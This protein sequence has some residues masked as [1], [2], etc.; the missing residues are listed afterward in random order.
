MTTFTHMH[1]MRLV[2]PF[3]NELGH[4]ELLALLL[5]ISSRKTSEVAVRNLKVNSKFR[6]LPQE[7]DTKWSVQSALTRAG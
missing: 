1:T 7:V 6:S 4:T 5:P 3:L 2:V